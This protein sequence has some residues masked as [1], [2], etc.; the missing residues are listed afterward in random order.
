[1]SRF[2]LLQVIL[3]YLLMSVRSAFCQ[4]DYRPSLFFREHYKEIPAEVP[5]TGEKINNLNIIQ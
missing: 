5:V 1:M 3:F 4:S 2:I